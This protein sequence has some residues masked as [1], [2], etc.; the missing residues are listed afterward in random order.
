MSCWNLG[1]YSAAMDSLI[2]CTAHQNFWKGGLGEPE[3]GNE[4]HR[5]QTIYSANK[6]IIH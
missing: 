4:R 5:V 3:T 2:Q 6:Q 1:A